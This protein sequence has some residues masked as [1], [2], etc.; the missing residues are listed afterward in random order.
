MVGEIRDRETANTALHAALTG[1]LVFSTLHTNDAAG[2]IPRLID[3]KVKVPIIAPAL[4]LVLAQR[5]VRLVCPDCKKLR[6]ITKDELILF[7][8]ELEHIPKEIRVKV[9]SKTQ[10]AEP[11]GCSI[12]QDTGYKGRI[13]IFEMFQVDPEIEEKILASPSIEGLRKLLVS[14]GMTTMRQDGIQKIVQGL[15]TPEEVDRVS[16]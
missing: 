2:T 1:H 12:C 6:P 4:R 14:K 3:M 9:S 13:G 16:E 10:L 7:K 8:Q 15:T 11:V 5:L